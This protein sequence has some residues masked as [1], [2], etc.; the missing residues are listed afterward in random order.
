VIELDA[1]I[2]ASALLFLAP[3]PT[4]ALL[5]AGGAMMGAR[6]AAPLILA[7]VL[8]YAIAIATL[9]VV[10]APLVDSVAWVLLALRVGCGL[11]LAYTAWLIWRAPSGDG[12]AAISWRR[13]FL[14][15]LSNPKA[16]VF[17]FVVLPPRSIGAAEL[18]QPYGAILCLLAALGGGVW[19][20]VGA[21]IQAGARERGGLT[22]RRTSSVVVAVFSALVLASAVPSTAAIASPVAAPGPR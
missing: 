7:A 19:V 18:V 5:A 6:R 2:L 22:I 12:E 14:A 17:V 21:A 16:L 11:Y 10:V 4:N 1:F 20:S 13:V 3:G 15:T 8:G 9:E